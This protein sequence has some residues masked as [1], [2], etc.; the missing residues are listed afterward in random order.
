MIMALIDEAIQSGSRLKEAA[1]I[2]GLSSRTI[3]RWRQQDDG[4][5]Q[6]KGPL[7]EP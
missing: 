6:R 2:M 5:D 7:T 3:I 4:Q 1:A